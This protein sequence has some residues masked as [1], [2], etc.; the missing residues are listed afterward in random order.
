MNPLR[1]RPSHSATESP[2]FQ[3]SINTFSR[4]AHAGMPEFFLLGL[5]P[6]PAG[7][8]VENGIGLFE[9]AEG[10]PS[11]QPRWPVPTQCK[12]T[13]FKNCLIFRN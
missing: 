11:S 9:A 10:N 5:E 1:P 12:E 7:P 3:F 2:S 13:G 8:G 6:A 4:S